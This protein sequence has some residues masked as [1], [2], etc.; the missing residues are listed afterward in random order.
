MSPIDRKLYFAYGSNMNDEQMAFRCP[1]A[2][3]VGTVRL[4]GYRLAFCGKGGRGVA[5]IL[6]EAGSHVDGV[7]WHIS[8]ADEKSLDRYEGYPFLYTKETLPVSCKDGSEVS[9][10]AYVMTAPSRDIPASP[11]LPISMEFWKDAASTASMAA[12]F[13]TLPSNQLKLSFSLPLRKS[14]AGRSVRRENCENETM[15]PAGLPGGVQHRYGR[16]GCRGPAERRANHHKKRMNWPRMRT[17]NSSSKNRLSRTASA[18][19]TRR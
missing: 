7:L 15:R 4:E 3:A 1:D 12:R 13:W 5:T 18:T 11:P 10:M 14:S 9:V 16:A 17:R 8:A 6:P 2:E 19:S